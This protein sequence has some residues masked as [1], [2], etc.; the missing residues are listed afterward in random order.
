MQKDARYLAGR[1]FLTQKKRTGILF[2]FAYLVPGRFF[3]FD[4]KN[5]GVH[6]SEQ[7]STFSC[8]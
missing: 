8:A 1:L 7:V 4:F 2:A 3:S 5:V 6:M